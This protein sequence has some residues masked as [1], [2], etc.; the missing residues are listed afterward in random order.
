MNKVHFTCDLWLSVTN[1]N[2]LAITCHWI[3]PNWQMRMLI[4][5]F[6]DVESKQ[7]SDAIFNFLDRTIT[8]FNL[9]SKLL[10]VATDNCTTMV[11]VLHKLINFMKIENDVDIFHIRCAAHVLN[12]IVGILYHSSVLK[13][14]I[15]KIRDA[16]KLVRG[17]SKLA[18]KMK[19][20]TAINN[21]NDIKII[22]DC[23]I[24]WNS[25]YDMLK[26]A[27]QLKKSITTF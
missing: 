24:R 1:D 22:L 6:I 15:S 25:T 27:F 3:N 16:C 21:E 18:Q 2:Y 13:Q 19:Q 20:Y 8:K 10:T 23:E 14:S 11:S 9:Q 4:L 17:S 26:V 12:L 7:D 5:D